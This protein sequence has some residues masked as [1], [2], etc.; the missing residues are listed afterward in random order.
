MFRK[1]SFSPEIN[2]RSKQMLHSKRSRSM[3]SERSKILQ[4]P[5]TDTEID[6]QKKQQA[7]SNIVP[8]EKKAKKKYWEENL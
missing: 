2:A 5:D 8:T 6:L 4:A 7:D 3:S 1:F